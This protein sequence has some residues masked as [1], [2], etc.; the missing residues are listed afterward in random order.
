M[1]KKII[2]FLLCVVL[3]MGC[4]PE[5][6]FVPDY[7]T[8]TDHLTMEFA[9]VNTEDAGESETELPTEIEAAPADTIEHTTEE[10]SLLEGS[11]F[12][13]HFI[14]VGQ[15]DAALVECDGAYML[16]DG[17]NKEDSQIIYT[18]LKNAGVDHLNIVVGTHAHEDHIGGLP[19]AFAY[20]TSDLTLC[21]VTTFDSNAFEDFAKHAEAVGGGITVPNVGDTYSLGSAT[22]TILGANS[23]EDTN[24]TSIV[25]R[26][27]YGNTSFLFTGDAEWDA[28]QTILESGAALSATVLKVGHHGSD[29]STGY[30]F[31]REIAPQYAVISVGN[32]NEYGHP[33]EDVLS[34]LRDADVTVFR[35]DMQGDI[36]CSSDGE[37]VTFTASKNEDADTLSSAG[38]GRNDIEEQEAVEEETLA[39]EDT[40]AESPAI[41]YIVNT[42]TGKF[43]YP[44]CSSVDQMAE[45]NKLEVTDSRDSLVSQGYDPCGR[46]DP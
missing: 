13:I 30:R 28:E 3:L 36:F 5:R 46:C 40:E 9:I 29:T 23:T 44:S 38:A 42:N 33:T 26:I 21:P 22:I 11:S 25:L 14:D 16:I 39:A 12:S 10:L 4:S 35:T 15:A 1:P 32:G 31:L 8:S 18:V 37:T 24:D 2:T 43:H 17:G 34:R 19:G 41:S 6:T 45:K 27:D 7:Q 20:A